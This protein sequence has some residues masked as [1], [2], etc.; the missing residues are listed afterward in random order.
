MVRWNTLAGE[1]K[2]AMS[3]NGELM[4]LSEFI[5][6]YPGRLG[7]VEEGTVA[8]LVLVDGNPLGNIKLMKGRVQ[9]QLSHVPPVASKL[10]PAK[11]VGFIV[12]CGLPRPGA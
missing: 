2:M 11:C 12:R 6:P 4:A 3:D 7:V 8:D 9:S 1:L 5:N 10:P